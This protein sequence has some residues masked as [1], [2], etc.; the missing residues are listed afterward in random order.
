M[1]KIKLTFC[2]GSTIELFRVD[3]SNGQAATI[4]CIRGKTAGAYRG[5]GTFHWSSAVRAT[6]CL[7]LKAKLGDE[8]TRIEPMLSGGVKSLAASLD[9][10]LTKQPG[11][12]LDMFGVSPNG[13]TQARRL[14]RVTNSHRKRGGPVSISLNSNACPRDCIEI[15]VDG[16]S[17]TCPQKLRMLLEAIE[18]HEVPAKSRSD[19]EEPSSAEDAGAPFLD[20][21]LP[22][23]ELEA[24]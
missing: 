3:C 7:L 8:T 6:V 23:P 20:T 11:W 17:V 21:S 2:S 18:A 15:V 19:D 13:K 24:A 14:F 1:F 10:A 16:K 5:A 4:T 12:L 9:Y 22:M